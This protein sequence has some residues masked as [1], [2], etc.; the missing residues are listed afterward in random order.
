MIDD[1]LFVALPYATL[2]LAVIVGAYR[3]FNAR[4][5]YSSQS[6]QFLESK[7]LFWG[8]VSWHYGIIA[9]LLAHLLAVLFSTAWGI[10]LGTSLR[11]Y[12]MEI[13]GLALTLVTI[14]GLSLL[15]L[16]RLANPHLMIVTSKA[17]W[18]MLAALLSQAVLGFWVGFFYR[19]GSAWYLHTIVPWLTSLATFQPDVQGVATLPLIP[20]LHILNAFLLVSI[21]PFTRL[22]HILSF[23]IT[24]LWRPYQLVV[25]NRRRKAKPG[26][27][28]D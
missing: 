13:T 4:F 25:W 6:S 16:R 11:L 15:V 19:W 1:V 22:V 3:Y 20:K 10:L 14:A 5:S 8:S 17:D 28:I 26:R 9:I 7:Q 18:L 27:M 12:V 2:T 23:P 24:Y 21:F